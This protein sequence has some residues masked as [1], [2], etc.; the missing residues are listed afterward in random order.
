M[1]YGIKDFDEMTPG[2]K[3]DSDMRP[4]ESR[5]DTGADRSFLGIKDDKDRARWN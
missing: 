5:S 4:V 2:F 1:P 3:D